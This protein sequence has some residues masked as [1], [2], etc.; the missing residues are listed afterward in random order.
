MRL[1]GYQHC[2]SGLV[3]TFVHAIM[4]IHYL[5]SSMKI[6]TSSWKKYITQLQLVQFFLIAL[7]YGQLAWVE[8]CGF[9]IWTA[10]LMI[11]QNVFMI[12]LFGDFYYKMY[13]K[14]R[15]AI[16]MVPRKTETNAISANV[17]KKNSKE[18]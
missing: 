6:D 15:P 4:Y 7:H 13:I 1:I 5:L 11:P 8:D 10:Y 16:K 9:P 3:N 18:Q 12:I 2:I 14:K 17:P